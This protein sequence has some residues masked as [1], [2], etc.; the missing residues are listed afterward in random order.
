MRTVYTDTFNIESFNVRNSLEFEA[1]KQ[2]QRSGADSFEIY[3][4]VANAEADMHAENLRT[5]CFMDVEDEI[6][7]LRA[8]RERAAE[9]I[10]PQKREG[11]EIFDF[12]ENEIDRHAITD[13]SAIIQGRIIGPMIPAYSL[14]F[15]G[16]NFP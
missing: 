6:K 9:R 2:A 5:G 16:P 11:Y 1:M 8:T 14:Y 12:K 10:G 3:R 15:E 13:Q 7:A 4:K